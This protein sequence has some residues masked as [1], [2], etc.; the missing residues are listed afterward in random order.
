M[1]NIPDNG[2]TDGKAVQDVD[3]AFSAF[4]IPQ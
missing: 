4:Y 2:H 1:L 3:T